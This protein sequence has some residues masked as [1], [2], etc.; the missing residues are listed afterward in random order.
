MNAISAKMC[1]CLSATAQGIGKYIL[2]IQKIFKVKICNIFLLPLCIALES[3]N[4][5]MPCRTSVVLDLASATDD[6]IYKVIKVCRIHNTVM[7]V[8]FAVVL[9]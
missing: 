1:M 9:S 7:K 6:C 2:M 3:G 5:N 4:T 8:E